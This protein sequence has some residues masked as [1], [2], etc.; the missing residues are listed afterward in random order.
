M[1]LLTDLPDELLE[2]VAKPNDSEL[3]NCD[4]HMY[5]YHDDG[6]HGRFCPQIHPTRPPPPP[7]VCSLTMVMLEAY[8]MAWQ[9]LN[10]V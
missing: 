7:K 9:M 1:V 4:H 2:Q 8:C 5:H 3:V 10:Y 6:H